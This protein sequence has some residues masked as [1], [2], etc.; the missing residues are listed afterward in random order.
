MPFL[1]K[2]LILNG[3]KIMQTELVLNKDVKRI[4]KDDFAGMTALERVTI[5]NPY[6]MLPEGAFRDCPQVTI[7]AHGGSF[8]EFYAKKYGFAFEKL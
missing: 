5:L 8:A 1:F 3:E 4:D 6:L 7:R 2:I